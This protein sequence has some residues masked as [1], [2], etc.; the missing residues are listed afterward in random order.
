VAGRRHAASRYYFGSAGESPPRHA[1]ERPSRRRQAGESR[2]EEKKKS[3]FFHQLSPCLG[4]MQSLESLETR[5]S[6]GVR[7]TITLS[8]LLQERRVYKDNIR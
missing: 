4:T 7:G 2:R 8:Y 5:F 1:I 6:D 3:R